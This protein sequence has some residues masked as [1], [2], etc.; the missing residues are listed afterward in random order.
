MKAS[1]NFLILLVA[2]FSFTV[3]HSQQRTV[4]RGRVIDSKDKT[5]VI[6][7][8]IIEYD[9][10]NRV[11]NGTICDVNGYFVLEMRDAKNVV[12]VSIVGYSS[13]IMSIDPSKSVT[14][15]LEQTTT[16]LKEVKVIGRKKLEIPSLTN[17]EDRDNASS[18]VK[19]DLGD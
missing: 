1:K 14:I 7:A 4:L 5:G 8:N 12:K 11:I 3:V 9:K 16:Q 6:G 17:I 19:V 10:D 15:E 18:V 2:L 13:Q